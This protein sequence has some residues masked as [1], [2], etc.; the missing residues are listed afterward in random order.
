MPSTLADPVEQLPGIGPRQTERLARLGIRRIGDLLWHLPLRYEDRSRVVPIRALEVDV[1]ALVE[2]RLCAVGFIGARRRLYGADLEDVAGD[3]L[4]L[5]FFRIA[6]RLAASLKSGTRVRAYGVPRGMTGALEMHHPELVLGAAIGKAPKPNL[7][8]VYPTTEGVYAASLA[9][10][11][12]AALVIAQQSTD[13]SVSHSSPR[14]DARSARSQLQECQGPRAGGATELADFLPE[15]GWPILDAL[16]LLHAPPIE[17][18]DRRLGGRGG[19]RC[20]LADESDLD[21]D[22]SSAD[23]VRLSG[24][25]QVRDVFGPSC[26]ASETSRRGSAIDA[27]RDLKLARRRL[28]F[29]E[30]VAHQ[31]ALVLSSTR[32]PPRASA[33][34]SVDA[35]G[36]ETL[37]SQTV[38]APA[39]PETAPRLAVPGKLWRDFLQGLPFAL[40]GAQRRAIAE[41]HADQ[42]SPQPMQRLLQGDVGSGKTIVAQAAIL[43]ALE[44]GYQAV[45]MAPTELLARQHAEELERRLTPLGIEVCWVGGG[46]R[47]SERE[48]RC[49]RIASREPL[50]AVGTH[51]LF[52]ASVTFGQLGCVVIDE[53]HRF[54]VH[55][56]MQLAT[57]GR[58]MEVPHQLIMTA[59]PIPRTL[60]MAQYQRLAV[61]VLDERPPGRKPVITA[62]VSARRRA[63]VIERIRAQCADGAQVYWVCPLIDDSE[64]LA[65]ESATGLFEQLTEALPGLR[66]GL[67]HGRLKTAERDEAMAAFREHR[68]DVLVA[69]TVIEVGVDVPNASLMII[70]N[71]ERMGLAQLHQLRG[72]VGRG[73]RQS[74]CVLLYGDAVSE[75]GR[76]RLAALREYDDGFRLAEIDLELRGPGE[77]LGTRQTGEA[78][79]RVADWSR[80]HALFEPATEMALDL[81]QRDPDRARRL[82]ERWVGAQ[83]AYGRVG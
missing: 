61:S 51:A 62:V 67:V 82:V 2:G 31:A 1:P 64:K 12:Q 23:K 28:S 48:A 77:L 50:V 32:S 19:P 80:D 46:V 21:H 83:E 16:Q 71:A 78:N 70:E 35:A 59:T 7:T 76:R 75:T 9:R 58:S 36:C 30:F 25:D 40:T 10:W 22:E 26:E 68:L 14:N 43:Q 17:M 72:R 55:Q 81:V 53:Q 13:A 5:R 37:S 69:T 66:L 15:C 11:I 45:F 18:L 20:P 27:R 63:E 38:A 3:R 49:E 74:Y 42:G 24:S 57:R 56:R 54:G 52:Q 44:T 39:G 34:P 29:E 33:F 73:S 6:P 79:F 47:R 4:A 60:A 65:A 41:I 8:P